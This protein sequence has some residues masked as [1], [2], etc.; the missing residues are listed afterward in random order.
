MPWINDGKKKRNNVR[1]NI[2]T[3]NSNNGKSMYD[4][5]WNRLRNSYIHEHPLCELCLLNGRSVPAEEVHHKRPFSTGKTEEER[6]SLLLD[7]NNLMALC[8]SCH[9]KIHNDMRRKS[10]VFGT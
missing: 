3:N 1:Y 9:H 2:P 6:F 10:S 8:R 7:R 5:H 4:I